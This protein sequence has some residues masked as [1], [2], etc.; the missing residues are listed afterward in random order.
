[1]KKAKKINE[2]WNYDTCGY[3][4]EEMKQEYEEF[5]GETPNEEELDRF[6]EDTNIMFLDDERSNVEFYEKQHGSKTYVILA[7]LGLWNGRA[8]GGKIIKGLWNAISKS[9]AWITDYHHLN[10][11]WKIFKV[12]DKAICDY[13]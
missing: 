9:C 2:I 1:M 5:N 6:I 3:N 7:D 11:D 12:D 10:Y 13:I 4:R 8:E